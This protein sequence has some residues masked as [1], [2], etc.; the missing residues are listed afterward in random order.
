V[1]HWP[2]Q[3][4]PIKLKI[5]IFVEQDEDGSFHA[6]CPAF[7]GLH[8]DGNTPDE[9]ANNAGE[10]VP[11]YLQSLERSGESVPVGPYCIHEQQGPDYEHLA[12][13]AARKSVTVQW[14]TMQMSGIS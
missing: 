10:L 12:V 8:A 9:A 7:P 3:P 5:A 1:F 11:V 6:F 2:G 4:R 14:P 13:Y